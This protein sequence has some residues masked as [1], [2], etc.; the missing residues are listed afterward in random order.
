MNI[1]DVQNAVE[2]A[3]RDI[4]A[5][6]RN[7]EAMVSLISGRLEAAYNTHGTYYGMGGD[8]VNLKKELSRFDSRTRSF[9]QSSKASP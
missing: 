9:K 6:D 3:K 4:C 2:S 7:I 5:A 8:L 1:T